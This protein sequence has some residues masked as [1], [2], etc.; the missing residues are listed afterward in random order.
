MLAKSISLNGF[1]SLITIDPDDGRA[2]QVSDTI[3]S[4]PEAE[5]E[6]TTF[7]HI[8]SDDFF[9]GLTAMPEINFDLM[10]VDGD[11]A[12]VAALGDM[13]QCAD[14]AA[15]NAVM[16]IDDYDQP[17]VF[18][19]ARD[20]LDI[21]GDWKE[22]SG[23]FDA[24]LAGAPFKGMKSSVEDIPFII[25]LGPEYEGLSLRP[26][27]YYLRD[28]Q[29]SRVT[30]V[31]LSFGDA[32]TGV[33]HAKLIL[34]SVTKTGVETSHRIAAIPIEKGRTS[35]TLELS[36]PLMTDASD[37]ADNNTVEVTLVWEGEPH[38]DVLALNAPPEIRAE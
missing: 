19:A 32:N 9:I 18:L 10:F 26:R 17:N 2:Q 25:L 4:W 24:N 6:A 31:D 11:H 27:S 14:R 8:A 36:P 22:L 23:Q 30:G 13:L 5:R 16:V 38:G 21:R 29:A 7:M 20:F 1:G 35:A 33:L 37:H 3:G 12:H 15:A 28:F 34:D